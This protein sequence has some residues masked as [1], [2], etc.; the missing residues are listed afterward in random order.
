M[1]YLL[2]PL[3]MNTWIPILLLFAMPRM[4]HFVLMMFCS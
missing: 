3:L 2:R 4:N 1:V